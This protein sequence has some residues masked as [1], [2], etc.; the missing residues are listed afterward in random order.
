MTDP[1]F[2]TVFA[3]GCEVACRLMGSRTE[4]GVDAL[5]LVGSSTSGAGQASRFLIDHWR[6]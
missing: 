1:T 5:T 3:D 4:M 6:S 2:I